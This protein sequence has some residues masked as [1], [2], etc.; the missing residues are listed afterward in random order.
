MAGRTFQ[1]AGKRATTLLAASLAQLSIGA[2]MAL[3]LVTPTSVSAQVNILTNRYDAQRTG[4]NLK[5]TWLTA[6]NVN[7]TQFGKLY[8]YP[9]DGAV[10]AQPLYVSKRHHQRQHPQRPVRGDNER[11]GV[12]V[13]RRQLSSTPLW[14][15]DF[16]SPP[17]VTAVPITDIVAANLNIVGNVGIQSTPV[18]DHR[19]P[20]T[21]YLVARTKENGQYVQRLHAL[22]IAPAS[23]D[24]A[25]PSRFSGSVPGTAPDSTVGA[26]GRVITFDPK[27]QSQRAGLALT[28]GVVLVAWAS[29]EDA[30]PYHG[31]IMAFDAATLARVGIFAVTPD[32]YGGGIWQGGRAPTIDPPATHTSPPEWQV[33]RHAQFRRLAI[34]VQRQP[35]GY[36]SGR[37]L[38]SRQ[39]GDS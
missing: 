22:D 2:W 10:Y 34:E 23:R 32:V 30:T 29:H 6:A 21:M 20:R 17:S 13:R 26:S 16:T 11:Q 24:R 18:I 4:A 39:R 19:P 38:H 37:L 25:V 12:C 14:M 5:E 35:T 28:N 36:G 27:M 9:V 31:W 7:V 8:S 33:G 15:R 1:A 3:I